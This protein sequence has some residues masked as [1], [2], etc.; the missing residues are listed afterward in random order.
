MVIKYSKPG[1][2]VMLLLSLT[3]HRALR[4]GKC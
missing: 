3:H 2:C 1:I 4:Y